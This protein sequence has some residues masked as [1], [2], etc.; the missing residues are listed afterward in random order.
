[1]LIAVCSSQDFACCCRNRERVL[2]IRFR[3]RRKRNRTPPVRHTGR[4]RAWGQKSLWVGGFCEFI[5]LGAT[6]RLHFAIKVPQGGILNI[7]SSATVMPITGQQMIDLAV[8]THR[9]L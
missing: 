1:M 3:L 4:R 7:T 2:E 9:T 6:V 8:T 5:T